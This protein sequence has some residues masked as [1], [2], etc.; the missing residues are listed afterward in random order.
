MPHNIS[1]QEFNLQMITLRFTRF[2]GNAKA[3][4]LQTNQEYL[5]LDTFEDVAFKRWCVRKYAEFVKEVRDTIGAEKEVQHI[6]EAS[7]DAVLETIREGQCGFT[8]GE[9]SQLERAVLTTAEDVWSE[10]RE[11]ATEAAEAGPSQPVKTEPEETTETRP[12]ESVPP[13][14]QLLQDFWTRHTEDTGATR[15]QVSQVLTLIATGHQNFADALSVI[16][17]LVKAPATTRTGMD[18]LRLV[19]AQRNLFSSEADI[20]EILRQAP[21]QTTTRITTRDVQTV[22][23]DIPVGQTTRPVGQPEKDVSTARAQTGDI[24]S[25]PPESFGYLFQTTP[26][27]DWTQL[28]LDAMTPQAD[29]DPK[30]S[31]WNPESNVL[32]AITYYL[33]QTVLGSSTATKAK[34]A[35]LFGLKDYVLKRSLA[36]GRHKP[37]AVKP[38]T[39][40]DTEDTPEPFYVTAVAE[41]TYP[42]LPSTTAVPAAETVP[43]PDTTTATVATTSTAGQ[44]PA[45]ATQTAQPAP[46]APAIEE[47]TLDTADSTT[48]PSGIA[49]PTA[50]VPTTQGSEIPTSSQT[51]AVSAKRPAPTAEGQQA[52][53]A[54]T[55]SS[56]VTATAEQTT[57][58]KTPT[59]TFT[60]IV[61]KATPAATSATLQKATTKPTPP[62][63]QQL[64]A[65]PES[66]TRSRDSR[67]KKSSTS[68]KPCQYC[69]VHHPIE[70]EC[71]L[72]PKCKD[73]HLPDDQCYDPELEED[74][75]APSAQPRGRQQYVVC[76][77]CG[78]RHAPFTKCSQ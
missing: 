54:K 39:E 28:R 66:R 19:A 20:A 30:P 72:C 32:A 48:T 38:P 53:R 68:R 7:V 78:K 12:Q 29:C 15:L 60:K 74:P 42:N 14:D 56:Q 52:K 25:D 37:A 47:S 8:R 59:S 70:N 23:R 76:P 36:G 49:A 61:S 50:Q 9:V 18:C 62:S 3:W 44:A 40:A 5:R 33:L 22:I 51:P 10:Q 6:L 35:R 64:G 58:K 11:A 45:T 63:T 13:T 24:Y 57:K 71:R 67:G 1:Q 4:F 43:P 2:M 16:S 65:S 55:L 34:V 77:R 21:T 46:Q 75:T 26:M 41:R 17:S 69:G 31:S 27:P 73:V